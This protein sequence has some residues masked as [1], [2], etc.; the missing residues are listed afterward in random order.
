MFEGQIKGKVSQEWNWKTHRLHHT[1]PPRKCIFPT[2][3]NVPH[4]WSWKNENSRTAPP[5]F[6]FQNCLPHFPNCLSNLRQEKM[7]QRHCAAGIKSTL[8][9]NPL[10]WKIYFGGPGAA[11]FRFFDLTRSQ[12]LPKHYNFHMSY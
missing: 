10:R 1:S 6:A 5:F 11:V 8:V 3:Y 9:E 4:D 12:K 7:Q 2:C